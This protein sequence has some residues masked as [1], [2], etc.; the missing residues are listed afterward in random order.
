MSDLNPI[1]QPDI[2]TDAVASYEAL[3]EPHTRHFARLAL[4]FAGGVEPSEKVLD[5]A[6]G[7]GALTL[8]AAATGAQVLATDFS[9]GMVA[10]LQARIIEHGYQA[11]GCEARVMDGQALDL[12]DGAFDAAFSIFGVMLFPDWAL[13]LRE[14]HRVVRPDGRIVVATWARAQGAGPALL[15]HRA[16]CEAFRDREPLPF[17]AGLEALRLPERLTAAMK[18]AGSNAVH[19]EEAMRDW[20]IISPNWLADHADRLFLQFPSWAALDAHDRERVRD[21]LR[22][23]GGGAADRSEKHT[24]E[25]QSQE[26]ISYAVFCLKKFFFNDTATTEINTECHTLSLHDALPISTI[27]KLGCPRRPRQRACSGSTSTR[28]RRCS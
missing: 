14:L 25:L 11:S 21:R 2:W 4:A 10:R 12:P 15:F 24:S 20:E 26:H 6:A 28:W 23:A 8:E 27:S 7:T 3:A 13:G 22:R 18:N 19:I 1:H 16:W 17:P 5:V 9:P